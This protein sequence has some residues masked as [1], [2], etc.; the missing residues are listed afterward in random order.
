[1]TLL[2]QHILARPIAIALLALVLTG[3][4]GIFSEAPQRALY[5]LN[6]EIAVAPA[7][8]LVGVQLV[9]A[10]PTA[11]AGLDTARIALSR[12]PVSLDY[13]AGAQWTDRVPFLVQEALVEALE[14]TAAIP[15]VGS[16]R[17]GVRADFLL[18][19]AI[20][21][22]TAIYDS[23]TG[24][25]RVSV[26][27]T[28]KLVRAV[29]RQIVDQIAVGREASAAANTLADIVVAYDKAAGGAISDVVSWT[30]NNRALS[31]RHRALLSRTRFVLSMGS[32]RR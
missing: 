29:D 11:P 8:P 18:E 30:L 21:D 1:M 13:F 32:D 3:C 14:K 19:T 22:F 16:S 2:P 27:L 15:A 10:A 4:G 20:G 9:V 6:P 5:R 26:K 25:P 7:P 31:Q 28:V 17:S 24:P 12:A 23:P